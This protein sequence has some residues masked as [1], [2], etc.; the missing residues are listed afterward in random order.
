[1]RHW[2]W[3]RLTSVVVP[4]AA[5]LLLAAQPVAAHVTSASGSPG[6][7]VVTDTNANPGAHCFYYD[8]ASST[9]LYKIKIRAPKMF[10]KN[11]T[12]AVDS[13]KVGWQ[14]YIQHG[15]SVGSAPSGWTTSFKSSIVKATAHDNLA[16]AFST[17]T[18]NASANINRWW[19]VK[20]LMFWYK[21]G[22]STTISGQVT[23][24]IDYYS[25]TYPPGPDSVNPTDC[26]PGE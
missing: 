9:D 21:P 23:D 12:T 1:M 24:V 10:A 13:Q 3:I 20:V 25:W 16:A 26:I 18:W 19:R 8:T 17:R 15:T 5:A 14:F 2:V 7:Y 22:S 11:R 6:N 4:L